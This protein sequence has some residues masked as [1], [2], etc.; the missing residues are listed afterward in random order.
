MSKE[1]RS[2]LLCRQLSD[3]CVTSVNRTSIRDVPIGTMSWSSR[4][5]GRHPPHVHAVSTLLHLLRCCVPAA[6]VSSHGP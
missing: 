3:V 1:Q 2:A 5:G 6:I 4:G